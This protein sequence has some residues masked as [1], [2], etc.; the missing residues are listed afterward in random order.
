M[1]TQREGYRD[2][3]ESYRQG[4]QISAGHIRQLSRYTTDGKYQIDNNF[5]ENNVRPLVLGRKNYSSAETMMPPKMLPSS[6]ALW[7][8]AT[9]A[10]R[11]A[12]VAEP[13]LYPH[14]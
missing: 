14:P 3:E 1:G 12:Q 11:C 13:L 5:I 6:T 2:A 10:G 8:A 4:H 7:D 9:G